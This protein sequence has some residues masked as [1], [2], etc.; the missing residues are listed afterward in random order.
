MTRPLTPPEIGS[1][2]AAL[3]RR[4]D[5]LERRLRNLDDVFRP[6]LE[7]SY[8]GAL[9]ASASPRAPRRAAGRLEEIVCELDTPGSTATVVDVLK[10]GVA[11]ATVTIAAGFYT[12][13]QMVYGVTFSPTVDKIKAEITAAGTG[14]ADL[15]VICRFN[16]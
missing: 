7:F 3:K 9:T 5:A 4:V 16:R 6:E 8:S 12:V 2:L 13:R 10:N 11:E 14:A 1:E 15:A